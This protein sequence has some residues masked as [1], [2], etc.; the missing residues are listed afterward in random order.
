[1]AKASTTEVFN[2][3]PEQFFKIISD[4]EKYHEFLA[5]V[6]QCKVLK[7]E[8]NRKLVEYHVQVMKSFK[9]SLWMT[10]TASQ[11][12]TWEFASGDIFKTS[13]GS[14]KLENE[15]GKTRATYTV[16]ATF[17]MFVPGPIANALVSV[18]LPNMISSYQKRVK[19]LYGV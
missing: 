11:S 4:Y 14:W 15:A 5:E 19:Q 16:E 1:M 17:N 13:V 9:Y 18:N 12:I 2:C 6:K 8:G 10:E 3:T 7:S